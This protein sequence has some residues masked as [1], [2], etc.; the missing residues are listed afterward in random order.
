MCCPYHVRVAALGERARR[1]R[2]DFLPPADPPDRDRALEYLRDGVAPAVG[3][4]REARLAGEADTLSPAIEQPLDQILGEWLE[5]YAACYDT[6]VEVD[7]TA[8]RAAVLL[9]DGAT[10]REAAA[11]LTGVPER[12]AQQAAAEDP[13][14]NGKKTSSPG[15]ERL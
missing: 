7:V 6:F 14:G 3:L 10:L 1:A 12:A 13:V 9:A 11:R 15:A 4:Y 2:S 8:A 5:L